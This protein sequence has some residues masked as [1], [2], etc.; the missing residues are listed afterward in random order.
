MLVIS[1][2]IFESFKAL[3]IIRWI[4]NNYIR[5]G[6]TTAA[7]ILQNNPV[8]LILSTFCLIPDVNF[9]SDPHS[10]L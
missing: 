4:N 1:K 9:C 8:S 7:Q 10:H 5:T 2:L 6:N 3:L